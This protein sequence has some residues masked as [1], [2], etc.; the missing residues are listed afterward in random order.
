[1]HVVHQLS[2][3]FDLGIAINL[4]LY[5]NIIIIIIIIIIKIY[6]FNFIK[7]IL[8]CLGYINVRIFE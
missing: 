2:M 1:M 8:C 6:F 5:G 3:K 4:I 7:G